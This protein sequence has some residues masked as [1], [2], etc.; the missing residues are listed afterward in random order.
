MTG[1]IPSLGGFRGLRGELL[2]ALKKTQPATARDLGERFDLT[3]N[4]VRR[5]LEELEAEG[6]VRHDREVRGVGGP[7]FTWSLT[8]TGEGLFPRAYAPALAHALTMV[9]EQSGEAGVRA[10]FDREW[11]AIAEEAKGELARLP[12]AERA[13]LLAELLSSRGYMA[14]A[15]PDGAGTVTLREHN[16]AI[17]DV[18]ERFPEVCAAEAQFLAEVLGARVERTTHIASGGNCCAW[19]VTEPPAPGSSFPA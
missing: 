1:L 2:V 7:V 17:R 12:L 4:A 11:H 9:R 18:A 3:A 16:C 8:G 13:Q 19:C 15:H 5:Y 6:L 14:E 10:I